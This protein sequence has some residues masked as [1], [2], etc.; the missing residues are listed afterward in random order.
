MNFLQEFIQNHPII[1]YSLMAFWAFTIVTESIY[2]IREFPRDA[3]EWGLL[4]GFSKEGKVNMITLVLFISIFM[5]PVIAPI[6]FLN[7]IFTSN[8]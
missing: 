8:K 1:F 3:E 7:D 6:S 5:M 2:I 4:D